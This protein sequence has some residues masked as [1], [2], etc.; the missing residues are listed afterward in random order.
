V[1]EV[2]KYRDALF[3][4]VKQ[5]IYELPMELPIR[6][7]APYWALLMGME[8]ERIHIE[9]S[10]VLIR[11]LPCS[12]TRVPAG[13]PE[14]A[15]RGGEDAPVNSWVDLETAV[16]ELGKKR[17]FPSYGW[18]NEY[19]VRSV[20]V[21]AFR[22]K[23]FLCSNKEFLAFVQAGGY[24][25]SRFWSEEGWGWRSYLNA[26]H[27]LF[28]VPFGDGGF[29]LRTMF[30][31]VDMPWSWPVEV[32]YHEAKAYCAY[33]Q[34]ATGEAVR[35]ETEAERKIMMGPAYHRPFDDAARDV[36]F[37]PVGLRNANIGMRFASPNPVDHFA[38]NAL[39][40]HDVVGNV[41]RWAEDE[42]DALP[43]FEIHPY[44]FDFSAPCFDGR[45][46]M[47]FGGSWISI[48]DEASVFARFWF[49]RHFFQ[50]CGFRLVCPK[51]VPR[52]QYPLCD[53]PHK[54]VNNKWLNESNAYETES[55]LHEY[56]A[57][58]Y[59]EAADL[60]AFPVVPQVDSFQKR[61]ADVCLRM[62]REAGIQDAR[63]LDLG[64][65]VGRSTFELARGC[66][67][68]LGIEYSHYFVYA[69]N[70]ICN[71]GRMDYR[72]AVE[73]SVHEK[74]V[75]TVDPVIDRSRVKFDHGDA[76]NLPAALSN[77]D[78][79]LAAN[80]IDRLVDTAG[81][82]RRVPSLVRPGG[83]LVLT[84]PYTWMAQWT[85]RQNW[86][87]GYTIDGKSVRTLDQLKMAFSGSFEMVE[88]SDMPMVIREHSRK[89]QLCV[90][91]CSVWKR[92]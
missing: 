72:M 6:W 75:A 26:T 9:T 46:N 69:C 54:L 65:G 5:K 33:V 57:Y 44:Y 3:A 22:A 67:A 40:L 7:G 12:S 89:Y 63:A 2:R 73:G 20:S 91:Q 90:P 16:V 74:R 15:P 71:V 38:P 59:G 41:W 27:P 31:E 49:R 17:E 43:G 10:S 58:S 92:I 45:H 30:A 14:L 62:I 4:L 68:V 35:L 76:S 77:Y 83:F 66:S 87:G 88:V 28:W 48:G 18:D 55:V 70:K 1:G 51:P 64:C 13:W 37:D 42:A 61:C 79:V 60:A 8:H 52:D 34:L 78:V 86:I 56:L 84:S 21:P 80:L 11:Q 29:R 47:I 36:I 32:N 81:F 53:N 25:Q 82:L 85:P 39:G 24:L 50:H 19:G 23:K